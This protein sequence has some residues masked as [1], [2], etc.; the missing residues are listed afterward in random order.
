MSEIS[1]NS[2]RDSL[3]AVPE[4]FGFDNEGVVRMDNA[5]GNRRPLQIRKRKTVVSIAIWLTRR[6]LT[7]NQISLMSM[8]F[9]ALG[10]AAFL[11][12]GQVAGLE[13]WGYL[14]VAAL[15]IQARLLCN[16]FDG[17]V[18]VE[19]GKG[20]PAGELFNDV[21]DRIADALLLISL[22]YALHAFPSAPWLGWLA[23]L[24]A[25]LTAYVR[26]LG[27]ALGRPADF[28]GPMAKQ[29]RMALLTGACLLSFIDMQSGEPG[30]VLWVALI[31]IVIGSGITA[32][33]RLVAIFS[34]LNQQG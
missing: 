16:L 32:L 28:R 11:A 27:V 6:G 8:V 14:I 1:R 24:L 18:A 34:A 20:T 31:V 7:P 5:D 29:H 19:G 21:P 9:A 30:Y 23:A 17:L 33:R 25:I 26:V 4:V 22:G 12:S 3:Q 10:G 2:G 15:M 13:R